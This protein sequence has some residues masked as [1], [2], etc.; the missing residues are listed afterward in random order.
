M[1]AGSLRILEDER[2][3]VAVG[4]AWPIPSVAKLVAAVLSSHI[5]AYSPF[6][7]SQTI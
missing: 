4:F 7:A 2:D 6:F 1:N 3:P 5:T